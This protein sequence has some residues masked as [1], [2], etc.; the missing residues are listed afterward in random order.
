MRQVLGKIAVALLVAGGAAFGAL[1]GGPVGAQEDAGAC[2]AY[3]TQEEAQA[4]LEADPS[5]PAGLDPDGNGV[6]CESL[7]SAAAGEVEG[8]EATTDD[9]ATEEAPGTEASGAD[10]PAAPAEAAAAGTEGDEAGEPGG[11]AA[12]DASTASG[13]PAALPNTGAGT[14]GSGI[15]G[16]GTG[17]VWLAALA[18]LA[19]VGGA[20]IRPR[21]A[22]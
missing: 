13:A 8:G 5:D 16:G 1:A 18:A 2:G 12:E 9:G 15:G 21:R 7:P 17:A 4:A 22:R 20:A 3:A 10:A 19:L 6:A 11:D 14:V